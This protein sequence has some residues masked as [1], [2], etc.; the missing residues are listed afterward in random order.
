MKKENSEAEINKKKL[1]T[2]WTLLMI[3]FTIYVVIVF[4]AVYFLDEGPA[5]GAIICVSTILV[6]IA[7]FYGL[8]LEVEAGYYEC[9]NC[10]HRHVPTY[11]QALF[12]MHIGTTRYLRCPECNEKTWSKKV[13]S[14]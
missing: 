12:A 4:A 14:K 2:M 13:M 1:I 5:L 6:V 7:A 10:H 9:R 11:M 8:K 3:S